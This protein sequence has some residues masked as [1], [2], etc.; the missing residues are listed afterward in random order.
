MRAVAFFVS[1][2]LLVAFWWLT[3]RALQYHGGGDA[4]GH[5]VNISW[6][7]WGIVAKLGTIFMVPLSFWVLSKTDDDSVFMDRVLSWLPLLIWLSLCLYGWAN[8]PDPASQPVGI[9]KEAVKKAGDVISQAARDTQTYPTPD[10]VQEGAKD[11]IKVKAPTTFQFRWIWVWWGVVGIA[12]MLTLSWLKIPAF[13]WLWWLL[14]KGWVWGM[15]A[16]AAAIWAGYHYLWEGW[17]E[18]LSYQLQSDLKAANIHVG[19][20][21]KEALVVAGL[22]SFV[23]GFAGSFTAQRGKIWWRIIGSWLLAAVL[24]VGGIAFWVYTNGLIRWG[25]LGLLLLLVVLGGISAIRQ[26]NRIDELSEK[27]DSRKKFLEKNP[28][29]KKLQDTDDDGF[30]KKERDELNKL[31][32]KKEEKK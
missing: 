24:V 15:I 4:S 28:G 9:V 22:L 3:D 26:A 23:I 11:I 10:F 30:L 31:L 18:P 7:Y 14:K 17:L 1:A 6:R 27:A 32:G 19:A 20:G 12:V 13:R 5:W 8:M 16:L 29:A 2:L 25:C 21:V